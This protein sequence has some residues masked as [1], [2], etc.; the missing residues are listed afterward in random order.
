[1]NNK[2]YEKGFTL[3]E[4]LVVIAIIGILSSIGYFSFDKL[5]Y[6]F[7]NDTR[8]LYNTITKARSISVKTDTKIYVGITGK[9]IDCYKDNQLI[10]STSLQHFDIYS[11]LTGGVLGIDPLAENIS[12]STLNCPCNTNDIDCI[13]EWVNNCED[14]K[15]KLLSGVNY[16]HILIFNSIGTATVEAIFQFKHYKTN[17]LVNVVKTNITGYTKVIY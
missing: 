12:C 9:K 3:V 4:L 13:I 16:D 15:Q 5:K 17:N 10:E 14:N 6:I 11:N 1:M 8:H 2:N 7:R